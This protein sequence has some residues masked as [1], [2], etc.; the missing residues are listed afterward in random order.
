MLFKKLVLGIDLPTYP[1]KSY[2]V[3]FKEKNGKIKGK[4]LA[5][6]FDK[7]VY[8]CKGT[9]NSNT[10][11]IKFE[12]T[13]SRT[14]DNRHAFEV[15]LLVAPLQDGFLSGIGRTGDVVVTCIACIV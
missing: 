1:Q 13:K 4:T 8:N 10:I 5:C 6:M 9:T 7:S 12:N 14:K 11:Y 3:E 2:R 15:V